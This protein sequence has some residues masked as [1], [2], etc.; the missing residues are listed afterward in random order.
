MAGKDLVTQITS[1]NLEGILKDGTPV[2]VAC[3]RRDRDYQD[4][5]KLLGD[6]AAPAGSRLN[7]CVALDD[8]LSY[9]SYV[10][11]LKGTPTFLL[12]RQGMVL[13]EILGKTS[14]E[15]LMEFARLLPSPADHGSTHRENGASAGEGS[16]REQ[17]GGLVWA[18]DPHPQHKGR[19]VDRNLPALQGTMPDP[20]DNMTVKEPCGTGTSGSRTEGHDQSTDTTNKIRGRK[21]CLKI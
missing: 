6:V 13:D 7:V 11:D 14:V 3:I 16:P 15:V 17:A 12:M 10:Y 1:D 19:Q 2:L 9:F 4:H 18:R 8:L 20:D 21:R 5:L